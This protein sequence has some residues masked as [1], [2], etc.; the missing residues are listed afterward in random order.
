[1]P[2]GNIFTAEVNPDTQLV[3]ATIL[4]ENG[5]EYHVDVD[6]RDASIAATNDRGRER[7]TYDKVDLGVHDNR[8]NLRDSRFEIAS[9]HAIT[10]K[11]DDPR[12]YLWDVVEETRGF[13]KLG[14][15]LRRNTDFLH[16][17]N[18]DVTDKVSSST[19]RADLDR[20]STW[21]KSYDRLGRAKESGIRYYI[22]N[23]EHGYNEMNFNCE[24]VT[25]EEYDTHICTDIEKAISHDLETSQAA[26]R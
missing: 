26:L 1:M 12:T 13:N 6:L 8:E 5:L 22:L 20:A 14:V 23:G 10:K 11:S 17:T 2:S 18:I 21:W 24:A 7:L 4:S 3:S 15:E 16:Y 9:H 19:E 25:K